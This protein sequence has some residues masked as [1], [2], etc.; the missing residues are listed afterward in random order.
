MTDARLCFFW[1][2]TLLVAAIAVNVLGIM[3]K[4]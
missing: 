2:T 1:I 3:A 4:G